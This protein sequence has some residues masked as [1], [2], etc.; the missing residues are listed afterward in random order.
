[1]AR[2]RGTASTRSSSARDRGRRTDD[3]E[4]ADL[5]SP[6]CP[7]SSRSARSTAACGT[8]SFPGLG[9]AARARSARSARP[10]PG[11][12]RAACGRDRNE[13][14]EPLWRDRDARAH[15]GTEP[16]RWSTTPHSPVGDALARA[17]AR[18]RTP[19]RTS[20]LLT[21]AEDFAYIA[22]AVPSVYWWVG[23]TPAA[24]DPAAAPDNHSDLF[25]VDEA[26]SS[27]ALR[28]LLARRRRLPAVAGSPAG[29]LAA[30]Q[31]DGKASEPMAAFVVL[32]CH[33]RQCRVGMTRGRRFEGG[34]AR[35]TRRQA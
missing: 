18:R 19:C 3:R 1:M 32:A 24:H 7:R 12:D 30:H 10:Q 31:V 2:A 16:A 22:R 8:T 5:T 11:R 23:V 26:A 29:G 13:R 25:Y 33:R 34:T 17:R 9:R 21:V 35:I 6:T 4:P 27:S 20:R 14:R 28:S 15:A